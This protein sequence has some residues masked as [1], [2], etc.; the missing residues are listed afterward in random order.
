MTAFAVHVRPIALTKAEAAA[1]LS[2]SVDSFERY[3]MADV[4]CV[5]RGRLRLF[6]VAEL[7][8]WADEQ[9]ERTLPERPA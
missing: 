7:E 6:P 9:A 4:R 5:R 2:M 3:V 8:R 1:A